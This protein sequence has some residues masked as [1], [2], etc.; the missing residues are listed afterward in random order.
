MYAT[1]VYLK[2]TILKFIKFSS[3]SERGTSRE[4]FDISTKLKSAENIKFKRT[5][6]V[7][8]VS[9]K[10]MCVYIPRR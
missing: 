2:Y 5:E 9:A 10:V 8:K 1:K 4:T 3:F 7:K 6:R